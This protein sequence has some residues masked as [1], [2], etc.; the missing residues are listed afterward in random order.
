MHERKALMADLSDGFIALPGGLG[1]L[2]ELAETLTW[3]QLGL[4]DKPVGLLDNRG[5]FDQLL[6]FFDRAVAEELIKPRH[7]ALLL[8]ETAPGVLLD[9]MERWVPPEHAADP[10]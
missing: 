7:R 9:S 2:D 10:G 6:A 5:F 4:H 3:A 1:T 8:H